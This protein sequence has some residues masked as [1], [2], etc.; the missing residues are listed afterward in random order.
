M[1]GWALIET[2][3]DN[4]KGVGLLEKAL[5]IDPLNYGY[6]LQLAQAY[7]KTGNK[8]KARAA[9]QWLLAKPD[10]ED[11]PTAAALLKRL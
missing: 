11:K 4:A 8:S 1:Y 7:A 6:R 9:A 2:G 10:F 3:R 5:A